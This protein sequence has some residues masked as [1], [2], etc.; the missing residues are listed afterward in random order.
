MAKRRLTAASIKAAGGTG[1]CIV[2]VGELK[3]AFSTGAWPYYIIC[4]NFYH[5]PRFPKYLMNADRVYS[6][7][8][9]SR[10]R[11]FLRLS[12]SS[13]SAQLADTATPAAHCHPSE[14]S[15]VSGQPQT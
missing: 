6:V 3:M 4:C 10:A 9:R 13:A 8:N 14:P 12:S 15:W 2:G 1:R 5:S 7:R 11:P